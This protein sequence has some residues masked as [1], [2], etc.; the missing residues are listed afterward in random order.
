M[1]GMECCFRCETEVL[2]PLNESKIPG[3]PKGPFLVLMSV[4]PGHEATGIGRDITQPIDIIMW[5]ALLSRRRREDLKPR[6]WGDDLVKVLTTWRARSCL[7]KR[8]FF[9]A[10]FRLVPLYDFSYHF[11]LIPSSKNQSLMALT[12]S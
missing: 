2:N 5:A 11:G 1:N 10:N 4:F 9:E 3:P 6:P 8:T 12:E 7:I